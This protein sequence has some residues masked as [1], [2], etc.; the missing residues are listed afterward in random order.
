MVVQEDAELHHHQVLAEQMGLGSHSYTLPLI[1][2]LLAGLST[3]IGG[4]FVL[5]MRRNPVMELGVTAFMLGCAAAA[6]I[7]VSIVDLF[8]HIATEI[9]MQHTLLCSIAGMIVVLLAKLI[10][11]YF[12]PES[13]E[14][15]ST[16]ARLLR[17]GL[18]TAV[19][20][21]MHNLPEGMAVAISTMGSV[22]LGLKLTVAI[23]LH[24]I[25]E[26]LAIACPL[27]MSKGYSS[28]SAVGLSL[29][30]G[31]S[32]PLGALLTLVFFQNVIT[33][34]RI[35]YALAFV[36][37]VMM[38]VAVAE[39]LPE[40]FRLQQTKLTILGIISGSLIMGTSLYWLD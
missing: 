25:P 23:A 38:A 12:I 21:T 18:I 14:E 30:S 3:G 22:N 4:L 5:C 35:D 1:Y 2:S 40:A 9:G 33:Q 29:A 36:G 7:T 34:E 26:G 31:L 24:N 39:L 19:T 6:M 16:D 32:E 8:Y 17:V 11:P 37:G 27:M 28:V 13:K 15:S 10:G 20:L